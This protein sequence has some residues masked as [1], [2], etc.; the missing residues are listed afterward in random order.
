VVRAIV[1][2][3]VIDS[4]VDPVLR[5]T[6]VSAPVPMILVQGGDHAVVLE[7]SAGARE[8]PGVTCGQ[9]LP[10]TLA[11]AVHRV[12][13]GER[14]RMDVVLRTGD[15][16]VQ[17]TVRTDAVGVGDALVVVWLAPRGDVHDERPDPT[18]LDTDPVTGLPTARAARARLGVA[19]RRAQLDGVPFSVGRVDV[20]HPDGG[21]LDDGEAAEAARRLRDLVRA[22]DSL[23]RLGPSAFLLLL[24]WRVDD[25][26]LSSFDRRLR[27]SLHR[28]LRPGEPAPLVRLGM[29][30]TPGPELAPDEILAA[31]QEAVESTGE[32]PV[33]VSGGDRAGAPRVTPASLDAALSRDELVLH[34]QP[35]VDV[36][37]GRP[38]GAEALVR[39]N[40]PEFGLL[41]PAQF[42]PALEA[43]G[44]LIALGE[45]VLAAAVRQVA[46]WDAVADLQ[47]YRVGVN[48]APRQ[49]E[50]SDVPGYLA[51]L[52]RDAGVPGD[53]FLVELVESE[54]LAERAV[55]ARRIRQLL[56]LG[57]RVAIDDFGSG[58]ANMS[59]LRDLPVDVI[60]VDRALVGVHP[61]TRDEAILRAVVTVGAAVGADVLL[62]GIEDVAQLALA[63]EVGV[64]FGQ[65]LLVG[66]PVPPGGR[67]PL[68]LPLPVT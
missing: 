47:Y 4:R 27:A 8:M 61:T 10:G 3:V 41:R 67:P 13:H 15:G 25:S 28:P 68:P 44:G 50:S 52:L 60:K 56:D 45:W 35:V 46:T 30:A 57:L 53:R 16:T 48:L 59:Y 66:G 36:T 49:L 6:V 20:L 19:A 2:S 29:L 65:G 24:E 12:R 5:R 51:G 39:W 14:S 63:R 38:A 26:T 1:G 64:R 31:A 23:A 40:H 18:D 37:D 32:A 17:S 58:F 34:F 7:A 54:A 9:P 33:V 42:I 43:A 11:A 55:V 21:D 22:D 62:E